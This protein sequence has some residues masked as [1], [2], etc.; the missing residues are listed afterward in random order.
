MEVSRLGVESELHQP[1]YT[2][3]IAAWDPS[4]VCHLHHS[5]R[6]HQVPD[7]L[8]KARD[9]TYILMDT[10]QIRFRCTTSGTP[11]ICSFLLFNIV[12]NLLL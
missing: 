12:V 5:Y 3:A 11:I 9:R 8:N 6:Q 10:G 7:R 2:T 4:H 1:A